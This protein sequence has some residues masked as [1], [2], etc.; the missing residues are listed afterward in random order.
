MIT[1]AEIRKKGENLYPSFL[2]AFLSGTPF[3]PKVI[4]SDKSLSDDFNTMRRELSE[5][6]DQSKDRTGYG[7]TIHYQRVKT[8]R[9]TEQDLPTAICFETENDYVRFLRK[10]K[11]VEHFKADV[12]YILAELPSLGEWLLQNPL[13]VIEYNGAWH[14]LMAVCNYF[15]RNPKPGLYLRELPIPVHT[16]FIEQHKGVVRSLLEFLIP[17]AVNRDE[18]LFEKRLNLKYSEPLVRV[19]ILDDFLAAG[20]FS[21]LSD[22]SIPETQFRGM[23]IACRNVYIVENLMNFLTMPGLPDAVCIWG[24][25]FKVNILGECKWLME[26]EIVYWGDI[27]SHGLQILSQLRRLFPHTKAI[28]MDFATL[29]FFEKEIGPGERTNASILEHLNEEELELFNFVQSKKLRLEQEKITHQYLLEKLAACSY[30][31]R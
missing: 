25:G 30:I 14:D 18:T 17:D 8:R 21:G 13:K 2:R 24:G 22:L 27:D 10:E 4:R 1:A 11:E 9:H 15:I 16:K 26:K 6:I 12:A 20:M 23:F 7:Y 29:N 5:V 31:R 19:R 28:L 3:F